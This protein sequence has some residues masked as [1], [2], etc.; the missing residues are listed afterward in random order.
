MQSIVLNP[1]LQQ[2]VGYGL[3]QNTARQV[4][5]MYMYQGEY[6]STNFLK[7]ELLERST[8]GLMNSGLLE[9][10]GSQWNELTPHR[11]GRGG[12]DSLLVKIDK[13]GRPRSLMVVEAKFGSSKLGLTKD[14]AQMS[15]AWINPRLARTAAQYGQLADGLRNKGFR[16]GSIRSCQPIAI[17]TQ[18]GMV[19]V[20]Q[21]R[22]QFF[23][24]GTKGNFSALQLEKQARRMEAI[25]KAGSEGKISV[26]PRLIRLSIKNNRWVVGIDRLDSVS[27]TTIRKTTFEGVL[28]QH[29]RRILKLE[30]TSAI[31]ATGVPIEAVPNIV[32]EVSRNPNLLSNIQKLPKKSWAIGVDRGMANAAVTSATFAVLMDVG[33]SLLTSRELDIK[34]LARTGLASAGSASVG[35]YVGSQIHTRLLVTSVGR[36]ITTLLPLRSATGNT[37]AGISSMMGGIATSLAFALIGYQTGML[38][39]RQ[40]KITA[41]SGVTGAFGSLAFTAGTLSAAMTFGTAGTGVAISTLSGAAATNAG[42][43]AIGGGTIAAGGGGMALGATYLTAG[44]ALVAIA[45]AAAVSSVHSEW[46]EYEQKT[47]ALRRLTMVED[48]LKAFDPIQWELQSEF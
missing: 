46:D 41:I 33:S 7:G 6:W 21:S 26:R 8:L 25:V 47:L 1:V 45:A 27:G 29:V 13:L 3:S 23:V 12:I 5:S 38:N 19:Y 11:A 42:L 9:K 44:A 48:R 37:V 39:E 36:R 24:Q 22:G 20:T 43:A 32:D 28:P 34:Q 14:G 4:A 18:D 30:L 35:Y 31:R 40:A 16:I 2:T 17:P 10:A 15:E